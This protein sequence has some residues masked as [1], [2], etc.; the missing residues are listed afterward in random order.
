MCARESF[1][2][3]P[4]LPL[5]ESLTNPLFLSLWF[6]S[7]VF[8]PS[9]PKCL[10][11]VLA[12]FH[13]QTARIAGRQN[14]F[15]TVLPIYLPITERK[16]TKKKKRCYA[17]TVRFGRCERIGQIYAVRQRRGARRRVLP[18]CAPSPVSAAGRL[19][20]GQRH[21]ASPSLFL[22]LFFPYARD[23]PHPLPLPPFRLFCGILCNVPSPICL[24]LSPPF[25]LC[26]FLHLSSFGTRR[27]WANFET[28]IRE[29]LRGQRYRYCKIEE[30]M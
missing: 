10:F 29:Y 25:S 20:W 5:P 8:S 30:L 6:R 9:F 21:P 7:A 2:P 17:R 13:R 4:Q 28:S 1:R 3:F 27:G 12:L 26:R 14:S 22:A 24:S 19:V 11:S 16:K 18:S 15:E 23:C